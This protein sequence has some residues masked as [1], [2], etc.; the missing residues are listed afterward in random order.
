MLMPLEKP[1]FSVR[2]G[3]T[4]VGDAAEYID[5]A[6]KEYTKVFNFCEKNFNADPYLRE[7]RNMISVYILPELKKISADLMTIERSL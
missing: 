6:I 3:K 5:S 2:F 7:S 1:S 4:R